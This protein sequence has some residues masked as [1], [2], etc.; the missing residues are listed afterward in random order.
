MAIADRSGRLN[1]LDS[2][3][4]EDSVRTFPNPLEQSGKT[5]DMVNS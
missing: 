5:G 3:R 1:L 4:V 2:G